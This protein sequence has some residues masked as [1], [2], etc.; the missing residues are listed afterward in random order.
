MKRL[1]GRFSLIEKV[2]R[3]SII[4]GC[5]GSLK[6]KTLSMEEKMFIAHFYNV[7]GTCTFRVLD[8]WE[9]SNGRST[10]DFNDFL[11]IEIL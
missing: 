8:E 10:V 4:V 3:K 7:K 9:S 5:L 6:A 11:V 1:S 2:G